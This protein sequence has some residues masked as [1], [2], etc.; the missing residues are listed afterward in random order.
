M[1]SFVS[2][3]VPFLL[4]GGVTVAHSNS[5]VHFVGTNSCWYFTGVSLPTKFFTKLPRRN[6]MNAEFSSRGYFSSRYIFLLC[7][8]WKLRDLF[9]TLEIKGF[10][11]LCWMGAME[12]KKK[13]KEQDKGGD[14]DIQKH[15]KMRKAEVFPLIA[16][17]LGIP[18]NSVLPSFLCAAGCPFPDPMLCLDKP[19]LLC[20]SSY[21]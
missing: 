9:S 4:P 7:T 10:P 20:Q 15:K 13:T 17:C 16:G 6:L 3:D 11:F 1:G 19:C 5:P 21:S 12:K 14:T 8:S 2:A 18:E